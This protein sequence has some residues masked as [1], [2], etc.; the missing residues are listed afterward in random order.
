MTAP[1]FGEAAFDFFE[2]IEADNSKA[3]WTDH[4]QTYRLAVKEP[5][6][7]LIAALEPEFGPGSMFRPH[8]DV[9]FSRDKSPYKTHAGALAR[10]HGTTGLY[11]QLDADGLYAAAGCYQMAPD[12]LQRFRRAVDDEIAGAGLEHVLAALSAYEVGG[13]QLAAPGHE[14]GPPTIHGWTCC[15]ARAST[16]GAGGRPRSGC[17]HRRSPSGSP[18]RGVSS[19]RSRSG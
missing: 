15:A 8:R 7:A 17:T 16:P 19:H 14:G 3:Y 10:K 5:M 11:V 18:R 4:A 13:E 2:G 1:G 12:Q 9:R 6:E